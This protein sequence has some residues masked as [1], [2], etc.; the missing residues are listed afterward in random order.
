MQV[1]F[2][3]PPTEFNGFDPKNKAHW[4]FLNEKKGI[5][6]HGIRLDIEG[7]KR[8][9][10][11]CVGEGNLRDR[12][13]NYHYGRVQKDSSRKELWDFPNQRYSLSDITNR[14]NDISL[15]DFW[16][17]R[18]GWS[19]NQRTTQ[20]FMAKLNTLNYLIFFQ[21]KNF[22]N[23]HVSGHFHHLS[24]SSIR[25][26]DINFMKTTFSASP[27]VHKI[28]PTQDNFRDNFYFVYAEYNNEYITEISDNYFQKDDA[29]K[30]I[31]NPANARNIETATKNTL[32]GIGIHTTAKSNG[33]ANGIHINLSKVQNELINIGNH[34]YNTNGQYNQPLIIPFR[35]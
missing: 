19:R 29:G 3:H 10:P 13:K 2:N 1:T 12:L 34:P 16:T 33:N 30:I 14:Y 27:K 21:N 31:Y 35:K 20:P 5:Y 6:I 26:G 7:K 22:F 25:N 11:I 15:Y 8:F 17:N 28:Q 9:V 32:S 18:G 24:T 23:H 4:N